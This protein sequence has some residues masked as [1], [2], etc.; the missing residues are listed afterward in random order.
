M[1][2]TRTD[3]HTIHR[4]DFR[5]FSNVGLWNRNAVHGTPRAYKDMCCAVESS[6]SFEILALMLQT[7][8][9]GS[10]ASATV[11]LECCAV[12]RL[13]APSVFSFASAAVLA[14]RCSLAHTTVT[15][16]TVAVHERV[17][18]WQR[19]RCIVGRVRESHDSRCPL[20]A[21]CMLPALSD[22]RSS[23]LSDD[24]DAAALV[25]WH[26]PRCA[27]CLCADLCSA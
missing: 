17:A 26:S 13:A 15:S 5:D 6:D 1:C 4:D 14:P 27:R 2:R 9:I 11:I 22:S 8:K 24:A 20:L 16:G 12:V 19:L 21:R 18:V 7:A 3:R 25:T 23:A 10:S